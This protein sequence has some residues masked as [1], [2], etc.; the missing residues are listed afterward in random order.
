MPSDVRETVAKAYT[1]ALKQ[2]R[3]GGGCCGPRPEAVAS[4][5]AGYASERESFPEA[6]ASSFGCGNPLAFAGVEPGQTVV[7]LGSGAGLDLLIAAEKV[8]SAGRVIGVDMTDAMLEAARAHAERAGFGDVIELRK[9]HIEALPLD[10]ASVDW[11]ISNCVINL[12]PDKPAVFRELHRVLRP[13]GR[14][15]VSDIVVETLPDWIRRHDA[16]YAA[17]IAGAISEAEY[18]GGLRA[19][20]LVDV[21]VS[22][23][24]VYDR[25]QIEG[26]VAHDLAN[27]GLDDDLLARGL[28]GPEGTVQSVKVVGRRP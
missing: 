3:G 10:D 24:L 7:D 16:A 22:E 6:A 1:E 4:K 28:D 18:V 8:G 9:G 2:S 23:R 11:V 5:T 15:S 12:S 27:L 14:F 20:G 19:A 25:A 26:M 21:E 13:G 17:C